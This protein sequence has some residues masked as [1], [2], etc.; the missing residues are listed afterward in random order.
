[1]YIKDVQVLVIK[2]YLWLIRKYSPQKLQQ[3]QCLFNEI[4]YFPKLFDILNIEKLK[5]EVLDF[6][7]IWS[8]IHCQDYFQTP[9]AKWMSQIR[10]WRIARNSWGQSRFRDGYFLTLV[11]L[12]ILELAFFILDLGSLIGF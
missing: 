3:L 12:K 1:M 5:N 7:D 10:Q 8:E 6:P 4:C 2:S 11:T 9:N